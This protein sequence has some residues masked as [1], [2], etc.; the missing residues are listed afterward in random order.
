MTK[1]K[2]RIDVTKID[3]KKLYVGKK[4]TYLDCIYFMEE[5]ED[6]FGNNGMIV[7]E[8]TK[9]EREKGVQG[10]ILGNGKFETYQ[11]ETKQIVEDDNDDIPF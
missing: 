6:K 11:P 3:K 9:E 5:T 2:L 10:S 7:Q 1:I 8:R 4:G